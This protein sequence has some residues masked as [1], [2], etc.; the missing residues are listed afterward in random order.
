MKENNMSDEIREDTLG[1]AATSDT[2]DQTQADKGVDGKPQL[3]FDK[4][5][6]M[7]AVQHALT[8]AQQKMHAATQEAADLK[9]KQELASAITQLSEQ[10]AAANVKPDDSAEKFQAKL[11]EIAED[12]RENPDVAIEKQ[13]SLTNAWI[14]D[15]GS[16]L[17]AST[18]KEIAEL[19]TTIAG[20]QASVGDMRPDY[21][22]NK[23]VVD[24]L[25]NNGM[26]KESAIA[27]AK[28]NAPEESRVLPANINGAGI[29]GAE[30]TGTYL[31]KDDRE[32]YKAQGLDD[33][34]LDQ[35]EAEAQA[36]IKRGK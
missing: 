8:E 35:M 17:K 22:E 10:T 25:V 5:K 29:R 28:Q 7:D 12:Y 14:A 32:R 9:Q 19:R 20:L 26:P 3:I 23:A 15:E 21:L 13:M 4:Y 24:D 18:S 16:K 34:D 33:A 11:A 6:D 2:P 1:E 30:V 27:W 31:S 36:R